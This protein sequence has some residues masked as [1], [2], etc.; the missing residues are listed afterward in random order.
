MVGE[1]KGLNDELSPLTEL[2]RR[3]IGYLKEQLGEETY[4]EIKTKTLGGFEYKSVEDGSEVIQALKKE[5]ESGSTIKSNPLNIGDYIS[6]GD[7]LKSA[8]DKFKKLTIE[9]KVL[10][11][12]E[13]KDFGVVVKAQVTTE[14]GVY[15]A[16]G[17]ASEKNT[18]QRVRDALLRMAETRAIAR[19]LRFATGIGKTSKEELSEEE[20]NDTNK[21]IR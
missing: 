9:T 4:K 3:Y 7:L 6:F 16:Y 14:K 19:A 8:H 11:M 18:T 20:E 15:T 1:Q 17:D 21:K 2:Q 10:C 12:P 5:L 13:L